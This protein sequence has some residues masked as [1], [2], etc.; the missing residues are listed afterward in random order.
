MGHI[1][2]SKIVRDA[3]DMEIIGDFEDPYLW[4]DV[5]LFFDDGV[6][7]YIKS[8]NIDLGFEGDKH[9]PLYDSISAYKAYRHF[10]DN[11]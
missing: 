3:H 5:C 11:N 6:D 4:Y 2:E 10:I 8:N 9:N 7:K 1:V